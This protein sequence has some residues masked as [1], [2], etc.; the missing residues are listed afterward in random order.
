MAVGNKQTDGVL[1]HQ[2]AIRVSPV[3]LKDADQDPL[4]GDLSEIYIFCK[5]SIRFGSCRSLLWESL[6]VFTHKADLALP[7]SPS[8]VR[9]SKKA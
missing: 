9:S 2:E 6:L 7:G 3:S 4:P 5:G 8:D 1:R